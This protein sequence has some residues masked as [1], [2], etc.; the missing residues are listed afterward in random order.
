MALPKIKHPTYKVV[1]PSTKKTITLRPFTVLEEKILLMA[2]SSNN[3]DDVIASIKQIV[4]NCIVESVD[5]DKMP[6]F[7]LEYI[8]IKLRSKSVG[9]I[10]ELDYTDSITKEVIKFK[11]NLEDI[12]VKKDPNHTNKI[13]VQDNIGMVLKYPTLEDV[14]IIEASDK[15]EDAVFEVLYNCVESVFDDS[16]VYPEFTKE[17]LSDFIDS[18]PID[19][20]NKIREF[21][22]T[23]PVIEHNV[24]LK[25]AAGD[26][27]TI[28]LKGI[29]SF[30]I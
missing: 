30:F 12:E 25:N 14:K 1:I 17:E 21:F 16:S 19:S 26:E 18:L 5:V 10:I 7:D 20:M 9:E 6:T 28:T 13:M 23:M 3:S 15:Q 22:D 8:F 4:Q 2:K 29:T 24:V 27:K 11:L